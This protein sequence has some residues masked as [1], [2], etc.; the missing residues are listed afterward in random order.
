MPIVCMYKIYIHV[1]EILSNF[2]YF[3]MLWMKINETANM[4]C[5]T[6]YCEYSVHLN[7]LP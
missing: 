7:S 3:R 2:K 1:N 6:M 5:I 4:Y